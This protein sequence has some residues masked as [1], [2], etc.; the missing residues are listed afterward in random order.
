MDNLE[1]AELTAS[2]RH[3]VRFLKSGIPIYN[4]KVSDTTSRKTRRRVQV[5]ARRYAIHVNTTRMVLH[6]Y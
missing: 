3:F 6:P 1:K 4:S 5:I 2:T